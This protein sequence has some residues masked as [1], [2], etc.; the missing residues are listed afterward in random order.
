MTCEE[1]KRDIT[2][3]AP[4]AGGVKAFDWAQLFPYSA[5]KLGQAWG[6]EMS[7]DTLVSVDMS[8]GAQ[9]TME[10]TGRRNDHTIFTAEDCYIYKSDPARSFMRID[11]VRIEEDMRGHGIG[12]QFLENTVKLCDDLDIKEIHLRAGREDG[13]F[14]WARHGF[15][16]EAEWVFKNLGPIKENLE[17]LKAHLPEK[18]VQ[19]VEAALE[20][21]ALNAVWTIVD[22]PDVIDGRPA[23]AVLL[24]GVEYRAKLDLKD[25]EQ[26][27]RLDVALARRASGNVPEN[28]DENEAGTDRVL[29]SSLHH[30][31]KIG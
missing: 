14:F 16:L 13:A 7:C 28:T 25:H 8:G 30:R 3:R 23:G 22:L 26:R 24:D 20:S 31:P 5:E 4:D 6:H 29:S 9:A 1:Y 27:A 11:E 15:V 12:K 21:K 17:R 19:A 10:M 18:S 2:V